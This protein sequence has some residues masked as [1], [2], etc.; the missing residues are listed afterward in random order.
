MISGPIRTEKEYRKLPVDS[1]S[2]LKEFSLD[3]RKYYKKY[4]LGEKVEEEENKAAT[5]GSLVDCLLLCPDEFDNKFSMSS[6]AST[7]TGNML[8]FVEAL[9]L[10]TVSSTK[11]GE[12]SLPFEELAKLAYKDSGYKWSFDKVMEKFIGSDSEIYYKEIREVRSKGLTVI[13]SQDVNNAERIV[14][15]LRNNEFTAEI[16][17]L[18]TSDNFIVQNQVQIDEFEID[19]LPLK[20]MLDKVIVD[21]KQKSIQVYDL[22]CVWSV[23]NFLEEYYLYRR[24]YI[25]AYI[26][27]EAGHKI[28]ENLDL[29]YYSVKPPRFIVCDSINYY[30]PLIYKLSSNDLTSAYMGFDYKGKA[31]PGVN[32]IIK[33]LKWAK[34]NNIWSI[35]RI[36]HMNNGTVNLKI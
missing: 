20:G 31:Y 25:Q 13:T 14:E 21:H 32:N 26:Y 36:N 7:P 18:E 6:V 12:V 29:E 22:K 27:N 34:E 16:I 3:R 9:Y 4:V 23:E 1:S 15:S 24:A 5:M 8:A 17:N 2:S 35:S 33:D 30:D 28:K 19:G 11:D 10:H